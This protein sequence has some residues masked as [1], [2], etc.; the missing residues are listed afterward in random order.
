MSE[1]I[2]L[3]Y[4]NARVKSLE[5]N[6]LTADKFT[7]MIDCQTLEE[8][9]KI[10]AESNYGGGSGIDNPK[11]FDRVLEAEE[12]NVTDFVRSVLAEGYGIECILL[13]NDYH[14]AKAFVKIKYSSLAEAPSLIKPRGILDTDKLREGIMSD[15]YGDFPLPMAKA[16]DLIDNAFSI[17][18][19]SPRLIDVLLDKA[20]FEDASEHLAKAKKS[21]IKDYFVRLTDFTNIASFIRSKKAGMPLKLFEE[22]FIEG[23]LLE[24]SRFSAFYESN[25]ETVAEAMRYGDYYKAFERILEDKQGALIRFEAYTDNALIAIFREE[26]HNLFSPAP[27]AGYYLGKL[28]EIKMAKLVLVCINNN[29]EKSIIRQRLRELYA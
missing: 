15:N 11:N 22:S 4:A 8:A 26:R 3:E 19:R 18:T 10:L 5:N 28:T 20:F 1:S 27:I 13:K 7:R 23:G 12:R 6:L 17:G 25:I 16:L 14:N 29:V 2:S 9:V 21:V 24:R